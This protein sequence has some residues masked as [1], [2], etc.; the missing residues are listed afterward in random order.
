MPSLCILSTK[1]TQLSALCHVK[2]SAA[3]AYKKM[4]NEEVRITQLLQK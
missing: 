4:L 1:S 3:T 2:E